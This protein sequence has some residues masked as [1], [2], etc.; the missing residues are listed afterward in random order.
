MLVPLN[1]KTASVV[2]LNKG[3]GSTEEDISLEE[4]E[5]GVKGAGRADKLLLHFKG[6]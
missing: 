6:H 1:K 4:R 2:D 5:L 3:S